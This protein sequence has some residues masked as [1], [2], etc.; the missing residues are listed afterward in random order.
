MLADEIKKRMVDAMKGKRDVEK[1]IL[2]V[3]LGEIQAAG[4]RSTE[5]L[6]D[7]DVQKILKKL[8]KSNSETIGAGPKPE[9]KAKLEEENRILENLLPQRWDVERIALE[10]APL[11]DQIKAAK[12]E[13]QAT[14]VAMKHLKGLAAPV[15]GKDVGDAVKK[16]RAG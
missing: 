5:P 7:D 4:N 9:L 11:S 10:L 8:I 1:E 14:G 16:I 15:E 6:T 12:S 3:A 13:G 2:R